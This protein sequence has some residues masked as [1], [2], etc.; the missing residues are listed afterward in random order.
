MKRNNSKIWNI[1]KNRIFWVILVYVVF[2]LSFAFIYKFTWKSGS[3]YDFRVDPEYKLDAFDLESP[4]HILPLTEIYAFRKGYDEGINTAERVWLEELE[5]A[6]EKLKIAEDNKKNL[7]TC[8]SQQGFHDGECLFHNNGIYTQIELAKNELYRLNYTY[9]ILIAPQKSNLTTQLTE[10]NEQR[11][12]NLNFFDFISFSVH[13]S[14]A[15]AHPSIIANSSF[16]TFLNL[17]QFVISLVLFGIILDSV[18][19]RI[20]KT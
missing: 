2:T 11:K 7:K 3:S 6:K 19:K 13:T 5:N 15:N 10:K 12:Q 14:I 9:Q 20:T 4:H 8:Q 17:I 16:V 18:G 1:F